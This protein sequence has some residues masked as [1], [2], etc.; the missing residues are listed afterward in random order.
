MRKADEK[1]KKDDVDFSW[2]IAEITLH[3]I[4]LLRKTIKAFFHF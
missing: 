1:T 4:A 3:V 2:P